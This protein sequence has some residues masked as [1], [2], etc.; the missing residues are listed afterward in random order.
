MPL[1]ALKLALAPFLIGGASLVARR[2]GPAIAGLLVGLPLTSG[3]LVFFVSLEQ[4]PSFAVEVGL[5]VLAGGFALCAFAL[6]YTRVAATL[7]S[8]ELAL[9]AA[10]VAYIVVA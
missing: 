2:W 7:G 4:G 8:A 1:L 5:A 3:P 10:S 9:L 6:A